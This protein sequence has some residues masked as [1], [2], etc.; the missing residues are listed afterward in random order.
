MT[1]PDSLINDTLCADTI[2]QPESQ[3]TI[4]ENLISFDDCSI[5]SDDTLFHAEVP[6]RPFGFGATAT[7]FRLRNDAWSGLLLLVCLLLAASL[8]MRLRK[9]FKDLLRGVFLPIPG[10]T[11]E[12]LVD[13]PLRYSTRLIA[14]ALL[15]LTAAMVTFTYTQ[16]DIGFYMFPESPYITFAAFLLLWIVYFL[17]KRMMSSFV[18][19]VF[20]RSE[21]IFT[22]NRAYTFI[23]VAEAMLSLVLALVIVFLPIPHEKVPILAIALIILV[24]IVLLFKTYQ[25]FF[26]KMYGTLHL[27]V[28]FCTLE[29][30][31]L[32]VLWQAL[33]YTECLSMVK[34]W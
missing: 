31:P 12:P 32:L 2:C 7:P 8:V 5:F 23:Y 3:D 16:H 22:M 11:D 10:K 24:K 18:N 25:I 9:K 6:Y 14:V 27:F 29:L 33:A 19:W 30:M 26:P 17:V 21:K 15:S 1:V 20:F 4:V 34:L 28:Y 13:D